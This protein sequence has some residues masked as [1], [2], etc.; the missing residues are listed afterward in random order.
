MTETPLDDDAHAF[1]RVDDRVVGLRAP[2]R[3]GGGAP[4]AA[5]ADGLGDPGVLVKY[6]LDDRD[7]ASGT[8]SV[9]RPIPASSCS[10]DDAD[11][12]GEDEGWAMG[13]VY[14]DAT[15]RS[16]LVIVDAADAA[17]RTGGRVHLPRRVPYGFHGSWISDAELP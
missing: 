4:D 15:D 14:D 2:L 16:D 3:L 10:C 12:S 9:R 5:S 17:R 1:P 6:D 8:T 7:H 13:L 11:A